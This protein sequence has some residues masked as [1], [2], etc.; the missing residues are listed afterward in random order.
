MRWCSAVV[1]AQSGV[2]KIHGSSPG[3]FI[4]RTNYQNFFS[5]D[6]WHKFKYLIEKTH[7]KSSFAT[8][9][10]CVCLPPWGFEPLTFMVGGCIPLTYF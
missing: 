1:E 6:I 8:E 7:F 9:I 5:Q 3:S 4:L 2:Q 10:F